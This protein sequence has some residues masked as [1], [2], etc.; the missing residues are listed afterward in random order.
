MADG[1]HNMRDYQLRPLITSGVYALR[2]QE[3]SNQGFVIALIQQISRVPPTY[4]SSARHIVA[5]QNAH[6]ALFST[7][8]LSHHILSERS[9]DATLSD[10]FI[11]PSHGVNSARTVRRVV[12][13]I[14]NRASWKEYLVQCLSTVQNNSQKN[15]VPIYHTHSSVSRHAPV[16]LNTHGRS[17]IHAFSRCFSVDGECTYGKQVARPC[18]LRV[19]TCVS[20][21]ATA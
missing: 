9:D 21:H 7:W 16:S 2:D 18:S 4:E 13:R 15:T 1:Y 10:Q 17:D 14:A 19:L 12:R 6:F 3:D 5:I 11:P 20:T 8:F